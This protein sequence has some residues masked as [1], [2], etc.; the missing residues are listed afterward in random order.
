[1]KKKAR[2]EDVGKDFEEEETES[3]EGGE[4]KVVLRQTSWEKKKLGKMEA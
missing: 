3:K 1:M 2:K 4:K